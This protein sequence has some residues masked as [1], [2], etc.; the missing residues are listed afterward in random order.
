[1]KVS[2]YNRENSFEILVKNIE[3]IISKE[4]TLWKQKISPNE[5]KEV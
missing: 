2:P 4:N 5:Q 3:N 1:M